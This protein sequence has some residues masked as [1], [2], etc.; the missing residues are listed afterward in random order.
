MKIGVIGCG[1]IGSVLCKFI[2]K[3]LPQHE[4]VAIND[5]DEEKA[6]K[7]A[8]SLQKKPN[9]ASIDEV[10][11]DSWLVI[12]AVNP[13]VVRSIL[14]KCIT[15][16]KHLMVMSVGGV[17]QNLE[18]L[19]KLTARLFVPSG[20]ICGIDG[21]KAASID[22]IDSVTIT[23]SKNPKSLTGA[24]FIIENKIELDKIKK[25]TVIFDGNALSAIRGFPKNI[26]VAA[27]LSLAGIGAEKTKVKIVADPSLSTNNHEIEVVG[28]FGK[29]YTRT[30][31]VVSPLNPKTSHMAVL[32][33]CAT[34][35]R[36]TGF[37]KIG[38]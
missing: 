15:K 27:T 25:K 8:K 36:L 38:N 30:E 3:E 26:N 34:L 11:G 2:D 6:Q 13:S 17:I 10:I 31:N 9:V 4:L 18:L 23:T 20:A 1:A 37:L 7:L 12:E 22:R 19:D 21:V 35:K 24:P 32:S 5:I 14:E 33:A 28:S 29:I 16:K